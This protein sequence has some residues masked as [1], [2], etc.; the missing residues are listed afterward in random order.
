MHQLN[1]LVKALLAFQ[2][3]LL[4]HDAKH[5]LAGQQHDQRTKNGGHN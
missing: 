4:S 1:E 2:E 3:P 5:Q